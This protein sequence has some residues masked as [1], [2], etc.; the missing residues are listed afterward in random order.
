MSRVGKKPIEIPEKTKVDVDGQKITV[1]G[2]KGSLSRTVHP[3]I[4]VA[5]EDNNISRFNLVL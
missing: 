1:T 2:P 3:D 5:V 4:T